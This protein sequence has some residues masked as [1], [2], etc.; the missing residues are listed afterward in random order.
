[1][2]V[3]SLQVLRQAEFAGDDDR[4]QPSHPAVHKL[5]MSWINQVL[6]MDCGLV[7]EAEGQPYRTCRVDL[8]AGRFDNE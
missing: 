4:A 3:E 7:A 2:A 1:M 8:R 6:E 5:E